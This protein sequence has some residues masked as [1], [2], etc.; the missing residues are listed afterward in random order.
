MRNA[1]INIPY[2]YDEGIQLLI[3]AKLVPSRSE[4]IRIATREIIRRNHKF[5]LLLDSFE[6]ER[7]SD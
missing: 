7:E 3:K 6:I 2:S 5:R 1:T 4:A